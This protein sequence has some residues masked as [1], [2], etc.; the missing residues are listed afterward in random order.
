MSHGIAGNSSVY[1][2]ANMNVQH[3]YG[4]RSLNR[5]GRDERGAVV[6]FGL[7]GGLNGGFWAELMPRNCNTG[8][9][10]RKI[11]SLCSQP[12]KQREDGRID[13]ELD[14]AVSFVS[15]R[16]AGTRPACEKLRVSK[17]L[18]AKEGNCR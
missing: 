6:C 14:R 5:I 18:G 10:A 2:K 12:G 16:N 11:K 7:T 15:G 9:C 1:L 17:G 3:G 8:S 13:A 4:P